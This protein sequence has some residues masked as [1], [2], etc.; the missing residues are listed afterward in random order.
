MKRDTNTFQET[1]SEEIIFNHYCTQPIG[2]TKTVILKNINYVGISS[3]I[4][5][6]GVDEMR[7]EFAILSDNL[8]AS[9]LQL[10][11]DNQVFHETRLF[12]VQ[13]FF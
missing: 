8:S 2:S 13:K 9:R 11:K 3:R 7:A 12:G 10:I 6:E 1:W 5:K 4:T